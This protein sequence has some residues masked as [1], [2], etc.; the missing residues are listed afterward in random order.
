M[1]GFPKIL[2]ILAIAGIA[3]SLYTI[4]YHYQVKAG[5]KGW[6]DISEGISCD[7]VIL[8]D[9]AEIA[10]IPLGFFGLIWFAVVLKFYY[11]HKII[12]FYKSH[13]VKWITKIIDEKNIPFYLFTWSLL[14]LASVLWLVYVEAF[15]VGSFCV[16]CTVAHILGIAVLVVS[17]LSLKK[18]IKYYIQNIFYG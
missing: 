17:Y 11:S 16:I 14:G 8:S 2:L 7:A 4:Y 9:Y 6:C 13:D 10:G 5:A 15:L 3:V 12:K 1:G 18:P